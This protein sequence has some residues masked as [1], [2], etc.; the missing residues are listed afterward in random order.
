MTYVALLR[1]INVG[2]HQKIAMADL[3][4]LLTELGLAD[5]RTHLQSGNALFTCSA[6][7]AKAL[8]REI[9]D[10]I[11]RDL[12]LDVKVLVRSRDE[13]AKVV[14]ANPLGDVATDPAKHLVSFL[15]AEPDP[16][17]LKA[18]DP[19]DFE[20]DQFRVDDR[21]VYLWCPNGVLASK[22]PAAFSDKR[23]GVTTTTRNWRTTTKLLELADG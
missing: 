2:G 9:E 1:G 21:V 23:L 8:G 13:L 15:A 18:I 19:A 22:L 7:A 17:V 5:V 4:R 16:A 20:P 6:K 10:R 12:G 3:R 14:T 11:S